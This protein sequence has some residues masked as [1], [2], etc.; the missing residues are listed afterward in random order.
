[1]LLAGQGPP[2]A[3]I[4]VSF[5]DRIVGGGSVGADGRYRVPIV[6]GVE[7]AGIYRISVRVRGD[8][9]LLDRS[10]CQVVPEPPTPTRIGR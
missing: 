4:L 3:A 7:R 5:G 2:R 9:T 1:M 10:S 8:R 6:I